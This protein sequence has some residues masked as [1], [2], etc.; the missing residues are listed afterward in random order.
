MAREASLTHWDATCR[1]CGTATR[2]TIIAR[3]TWTDY[4][5]VDEG[6]RAAIGTWDFAMGRC[7]GC[8]TVSFLQ[9][10]TDGG[11]TQLSVDGTE[12]FPLWPN[13]T[14]RR[15]LSLNDKP[16]IRRV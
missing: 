12:V 4:E 14:P 3:E 13:R 1:R 2:H 5:E 10:Y 8:Q 16:G 15:I 6:H 11:P 7:G 9:H